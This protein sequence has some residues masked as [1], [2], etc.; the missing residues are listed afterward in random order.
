MLPLLLLLLGNSTFFCTSFQNSAVMNTLV[1]SVSVV[2]K[3]SEVLSNNVITG[4]GPVTVDAGNIR[5]KV[6]KTESDDVEGK[7]WIKRLTL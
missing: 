3:V 2:D 6:Q 4:E 5:I 1:R 7:Y